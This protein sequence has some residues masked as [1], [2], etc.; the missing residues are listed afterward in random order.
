MSL[1]VGNT[2]PIAVKWDQCRI[3]TT[4]HALANGFDAMNDMVPLERF[5]PRPLFQSSIQVVDGISDLALC[6]VSLRL[7]RGNCA[8]SLQDSA[9]GDI[10]RQDS[11][12]RPAFAV[13][14]RHHWT[15]Y[16]PPQTAWKEQPR[17]RGQVPILHPPN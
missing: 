13:A 3:Q 10:P 12:T 17:R 11:E 8:D 14:E 1:A 7:I 16:S 2:W 4:L 5:F 15:S 9:A 6:N